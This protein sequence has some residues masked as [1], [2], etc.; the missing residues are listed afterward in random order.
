MFKQKKELH[1]SYFI[2]KARNDQAYD[3]RHVKSQ[4]RWK[5]RPLVPVNQLVKA[6]E[7]LWREIKNATP[8]NTQMTRKKSNLI[9]HKVLLVWIDNQ[10]SH[11]F[12][13][14]QSLIQS[15]TQALFTSMKA[16]RSEKSPEEKF[17][18]T[19]GWSMRSKDR[20]LVHNIKI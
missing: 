5:T 17:E 19:R 13:L 8:V 14:S 15:K 18:T 6:E 9:A 10:T 20:S 4:D 16:E 11:N 3:E 12:S 7:K 1:I 2:S